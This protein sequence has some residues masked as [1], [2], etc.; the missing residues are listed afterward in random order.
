MGI[1][2]A[3]QG[4]EMAHV[5][6]SGADWNGLAEYCTGGHTFV[7]QKNSGGKKVLKGRRTG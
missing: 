3:N 7:R 1:S 5:P 4:K 6:T 2:R